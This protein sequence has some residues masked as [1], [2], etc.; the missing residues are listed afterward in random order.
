MTPSSPS[1]RQDLHR[2]VQ[3]DLSRRAAR[4]PGQASLWR[5]LRFVG[6]VGWPIALLST[7]GA[8]LGR[9]LD[10]RFDTGVRF[11]LMFI[12]VGAAIGC[13]TAWRAL[14]ERHR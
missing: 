12:T 11:T 10:G 6:M 9:Y 8:L 13:Y 14:T 1:P 3:R 2:A 5:S 4:E 7:G